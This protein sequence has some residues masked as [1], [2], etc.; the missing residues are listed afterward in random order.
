MDLRNT[1]ITEIDGFYLVHTEKS[2]RVEMRDRKCYGLSLCREGQITYV[3][4]GRE[5]VSDRNCAVILPKYGN[6][7]IR[8]DKPGQF[9]VINFDC[10]A[11]LCDT[12]TVIPVQNPE[13]LLKTYDRIS[14]LF[15]SNG[16]RMQIFSIFY[17]MLHQSE[18]KKHGMSKWLRT[19]SLRTE[20]C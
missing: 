6:Y 18:R 8:G 15:Y 9:P 19:R 1:V 20:K 11:Y 13:Q 4:N 16:N 5:Y 17:E 10:Q 14:K 7:L 3:Q 2:W 12:V